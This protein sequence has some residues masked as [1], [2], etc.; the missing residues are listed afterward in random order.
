[1]IRSGAAEASRRIEIAAEEA[2][3]DRMHGDLERRGCGR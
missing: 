1:M 3:G 2:R